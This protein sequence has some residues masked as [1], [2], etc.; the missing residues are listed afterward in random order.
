MTAKRPK[1]ELQP[2]VCCGA[3]GPER[4]EYPYRGHRRGCKLAAEWRLQH[5]KPKHVHR[6]LSGEHRTYTYGGCVNPD[7]CNPRAHGECLW[8][9]VCR[10]GATRKTNVYGARQRKQNTEQGPWERRS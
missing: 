3:L 7:N 8:I 9:D 1:I 6:A 2:C 5:P 4:E 10:C